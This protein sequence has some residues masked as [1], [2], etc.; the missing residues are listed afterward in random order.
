MA[1]AAPKMDGILATKFKPGQSGNPSGR[2][3]IPSDITEA[4][5]IS[6]FEFER[7]VNRFL[8]GTTEELEKALAPAAK[9]KLTAFE[10]LVGGIIQKAIQKK[11]AKMGEW[12]LARTL[13]KMRE[14][15]EIAPIN[16]KGGGT[17]NVQVNVGMGLDDP[18]LTM[19][20]LQ[21]LERKVAELT[22]QIPKANEHFATV[23]DATIVEPATPEEEPDPCLTDSTT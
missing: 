12:I 4:R 16:P 20:Q 21:E 11:D 6:Q 5:K 9:K 7:I 22:T 14:R 15:L 3:A 8:F 17:T 19:E 1:N 2:V 13:G 10:A 23:V 18:S